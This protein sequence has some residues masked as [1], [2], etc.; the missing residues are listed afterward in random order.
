LIELD[1]VV[2]FVGEHYYNKSKIGIKKTSTKRKRG[3][4]H[5]NKES[6][7]KEIHGN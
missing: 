3:E 2:V 5:P 7:D 4:D 1:E 6:S